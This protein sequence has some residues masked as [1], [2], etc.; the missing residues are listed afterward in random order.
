MAGYVSVTGGIDAAAVPRKIKDND[1]LWLYAA[2]CWH[3][4][5]YDWIPME[6]GELA[7]D[8]SFAPGRIT[9]EAPYAGEVYCGYGG[10]GQK[11]GRHPLGSA[12]WDEAAAPTQL[13]LLQAALQT[14]LDGMDFGQ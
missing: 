5:Y 7:D 3:G 10:G 1:A 11:R 4:L 2:E 8:V 13:P 12:F 6:T 14:Y 9:H